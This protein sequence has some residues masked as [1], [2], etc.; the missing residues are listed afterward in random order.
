MGQAGSAPARTTLP[1]LAGPIVALLGFA[2]MWAVVRPASQLG[3]R[4]ALLIAASG[5]IG[6][7]TQELTDHGVR[8]HDCRLILERVHRHEEWRRHGRRSGSYDVLAERLRSRRRSVA[9]ALEVD[10]VR[11]HDLR[12]EETRHM[13]KRVVVVGRALG[14]M[15]AEPSEPWTV[16][17]LGREIGVSRSVLAAR[18]T[19]MVGHAP[20]HYLTL[21]RM[22]LATR[23]LHDGQHVQDVAAAVG[24][25]SE[26]AFSRAFKKLMGQ[27]PVTWRR[28]ARA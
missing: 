20:M 2:A 16:E 22:Q 11:H 4:P 27:P 8:K 3:T 17:G 26:A 14:A 15:H 12:F 13:T 24:Y 5:L 1:A 18:F 21:W 23:M 25:E 28:R 10:G 9:Y 6:G 19:E 7:E